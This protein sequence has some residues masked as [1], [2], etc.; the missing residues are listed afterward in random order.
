MSFSAPVHYSQLSADEQQS[1]A[2]L[3][4]DYCS[5]AGQD[6]FVRGTLEIPVHG[7]EQPFVWGV[8]VSLSRP[9]F[10]RYLE[11][12]QGPSVDAGPFFGWFCNKL[13]G[14][15]DTMLLKTNVY[16]RSGHLRPR[17]ELEPTDHPLAVQQREGMS[18]EEVR[19]I[20]EVHL[21]Q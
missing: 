7:R 9:N 12:L 21:H 2:V 17:I 14:F 3:T 15:P 16:F 6:F 19:R 20:L 10:E 13:A 8:W 4:A 18:E 1:Q 5:I 11:T